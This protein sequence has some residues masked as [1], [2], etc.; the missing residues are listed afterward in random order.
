MPAPKK[1]K[2]RLHLRIFLRKFYPFLIMH[3]VTNVPDG[4][5]VVA[6]T[7]EGPRCAITHTRMIFV[8]DPVGDGMLSKEHWQKTVDVMAQVQSGRAPEYEPGKG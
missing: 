2:P 4:W 7:G 8:Y 3:S 6:S 5:V 1:L